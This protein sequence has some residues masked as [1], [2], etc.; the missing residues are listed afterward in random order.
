MVFSELLLF[1]MSIGDSEVLQPTLVSPNMHR[2]IP[3]AWGLYDGDN[4]FQITGLHNGP[5]SLFW[6][7]VQ[8]TNRHTNSTQSHMFTIRSC[9]HMPKPRKMTHHQ[10]NTKNENR[11]LRL[12]RS[13]F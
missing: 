2:Q 8:E 10:E 6:Q 5:L 9:M 7:S 12:I 1:S 13:E 11:L 4:Q 3:H